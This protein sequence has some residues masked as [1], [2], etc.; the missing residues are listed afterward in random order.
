MSTPRDRGW[1][2]PD[3]PNYRRDHI[4]VVEARGIR[5]AVRRE[6]AG[7][8]VGFLEDLCATG[9]RLDVVADD[10]GYA[11]RCI[12]G[13]GAG[14]GRPC[15]KSNHSWG[16]AIDVNATTN[17]MTEAH[18]SHAGRPGHDARG[19]HTDMPA[20]TGA[21]A[22][23][24]GL[25]WGANYSGTRK[26]AMHFEFMGTPRDVH[27]YPTSNPPPPPSST[28]GPSYLDESMTPHFVTL[29]AKGAHLDGQGNGYWDLAQFPW[30]RTVVVT[31]N[32]ADPAT[33]RAY[34]VPDVAFIKRGDGI[35]VIVEEGIAGHGLDV[36]I[37]TVG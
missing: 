35:R 32:V 20:E 7:L 36:R 22:A 34:N 24:W 33:A 1:G 14:T 27:R 6:V 28:S 15:V 13:T 29:H 23:K 4:V 2:N 16:L 21:L 8:F 31:P 25:R 9:Y 12:R 11:N 5:L 26:D 10:W 18:A 37:W 30:E 19:V 17:P 3:A